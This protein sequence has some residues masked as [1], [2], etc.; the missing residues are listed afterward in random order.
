M[1]I[2]YDAD[3]ALFLLIME[4]IDDSFKNELNLNELDDDNYELIKIVLLA[5][6]SNCYLVSQTHN[7][8]KSKHWWYESYL[9]MMT[10]NIKSIKNGKITI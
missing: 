7:V 2:K 6:F 9:Y 1:S 8:V 10:Y 3:Y 5:L 4:E